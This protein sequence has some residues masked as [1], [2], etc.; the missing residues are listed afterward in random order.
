MK[1]FAEDRRSPR[2]VEQDEADEIGTGIHQQIERRLLRRVGVDGESLG[3]RG[4][5]GESIQG[6]SGSEPA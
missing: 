2:L 1:R 5:R 4:N 3:G 6:T